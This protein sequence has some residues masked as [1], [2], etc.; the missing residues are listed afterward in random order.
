[1]SWG[2]SP[3]GEFSVRSAYAFLSQNHILRPNMGSFFHR[4]WRIVA[5]KR[6]RVFFWLVGNQVIM[7]NEERMRRHLRVSDVCEVCHGGVESILHILRDCP[8][9][10]GIW[11]RIVPTRLKQAFF[12][13]SLLEWVYENLG[14]EVSVDGIA[15]PTI[16]ALAVW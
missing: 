1:M 11:A 6:V 9:M 10:L 3:D 14:S 8:A 5:P 7:T 16:F 15:W 4:I 12:N 13:K 2:G